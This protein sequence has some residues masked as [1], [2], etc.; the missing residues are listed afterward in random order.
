MQHR[1]EAERGG[2][3][4]EEG[5]QIKVGKALIPQT[6]PVI[7]CVWGQDLSSGE[8]ENRDNSQYKPE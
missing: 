8:W 1:G 5:M 7:V 4:Q 6:G 2:G 3:R